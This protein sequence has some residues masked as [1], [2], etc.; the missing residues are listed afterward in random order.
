MCTIQQDVDGAIRR[1]QE[2]VRTGEQRALQTADDEPRLAAGS[3]LRRQVADW[4]GAQR[5]NWGRALRPGAMP[6]HS[7]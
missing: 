1:Y 7:G 6:A 5:A 3:R 2:L 4:L